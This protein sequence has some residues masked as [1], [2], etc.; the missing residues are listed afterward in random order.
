MASEVFSLDS[1]A[2]DLGPSI[3]SLIVGA[4]Q[5]KLDVNGEGK[6]NSSRSR[7]DKVGGILSRV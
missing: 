1:P 2:V 3:T 6:D 7:T 5:T 4:Q